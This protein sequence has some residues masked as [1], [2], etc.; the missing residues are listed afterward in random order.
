MLVVRVEMWSAVTG[1]KSEI[2]RMHIVN[3]ATGTKHCGNYVGYAFRGRTTKALD[4]LVAQRTGRVNH[5]PRLRS[6]V[7]NLLV[8]ML[9]RMDYG[10]FK[11]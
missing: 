11:K 2:A 8:E 9:V 1:E 3:D 6:H 7:W 4:E 5:F 10:E